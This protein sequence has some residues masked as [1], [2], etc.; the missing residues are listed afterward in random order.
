MA[1][2]VL[3]SSKLPMPQFPGTGQGEGRPEGLDTILLVCDGE[4]LVVTTH[5][6]RVADSVPPTVPEG[7]T[8][9]FLPTTNA[10][11]G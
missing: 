8:L 10:K 1:P 5:R 4:K 6:S 7:S 3:L 2:G 9:S 11:M